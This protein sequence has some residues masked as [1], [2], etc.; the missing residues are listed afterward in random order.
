MEEAPLAFLDKVV[1]TETWEGDLEATMMPG[2]KM[3][4]VETLVDATWEALVDN[5]LVHRPAGTTL[6]ISGILLRNFDLGHDSMRYE[7][8]MKICDVL[9]QKL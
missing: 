4:G 1:L 9:F 3:A 7:L 5:N 2:Y 8:D 6:E